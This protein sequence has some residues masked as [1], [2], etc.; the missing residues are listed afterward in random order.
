M[1]TGKPARASPSRRTPMSPELQPTVSVTC[2]VRDCPPP[3][4]V[5]VSV[6]VP[7]VVFELVDTVSVEVLSVVGLGLNTA[8]ERFGSPLTENAT[9]E[10]KPASRFTVIEYVVD[11]P[12]LMLWLG[13][14]ALSVKPAG[15]GAV[16][17]APA[18]SV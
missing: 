4:P 3:V 12:R 18:T 15:A 16:L 7:R 2:V 17:G 8:D 14:L 11:W 6:R 10:P 9:D 5:M 13:G 1:G